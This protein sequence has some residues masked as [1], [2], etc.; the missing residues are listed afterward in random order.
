MVWPIAKLIL[1]RV[2]LL[3]RESPGR[4]AKKR[5]SH[6]KGD[7]NVKW[8]IANL[9]ALFIKENI[10]P[11]VNRFSK[12]AKQN[13]QFCAVIERIAQSK[14]YKINIYLCY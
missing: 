10:R 1:Q 7:E 6:L 11:A 13:P 2:A 8:P 4:I 12:S 14:N 3:V 9:A 5:Q